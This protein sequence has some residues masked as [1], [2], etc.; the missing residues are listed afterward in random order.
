MKQIYI[1]V[2]LFAFSTTFGQVVKGAPWDMG[3]VQRR[4][5][6]PTLEE[7]AKHAEDYFK[8][9]DRN[10]KGSGFK[11]F[12]RWEYH[13][14]NYLKPDGTIAPVQD[15]WSAWEQK[16]ALGQ[17]S[18]S[19]RMDNSDWKPLGPYTNSNT[20]SANNLKQ[21]GQG[22]VNAIA[23]DPNN[24]NTY[25]IGAPAGGIWKS[26]D[27]GL[28]WTP[29]TDHLP[30][31][32]VSGIAINP[33]N[34]N[35]IYI[36]TGD[37]DANDSPTVGVW[38]TTDGG[39]TWNNTG[40]IPGSP[41]SMN[42]I[43]FDPNNTNTLLVATSTGVQKTTNGG[44]SWTT[45]LAGNIIDIK[46]K[47]GDA[48]IWY[49]VSRD[50]FYKSTDG[51]ESFNEVALPGLGTSG[52]LTMDVTIADPDYVYVVSA[53]GN[54]AFNGI[55][56]STNSGTSFTKTAETDD[57]F[58]STQAWFDLALTVSDKNADIIYVGVLDIWKSING[59]DSFTKINQ[60]FNPNT[61]TYTHADIHFLRFIDGKFFAGTDGGIFVSTDEARSFTD[62]TKNLAISQFYRISVSQQKP[63]I[64]AGGLQ[65]NGGFGYD[66]KDWRN[67]HGGDGMEGQV[68]PN[69]FK[70]FYGFTQFGG[71]L[72][73]SSNSGQSTSLR[74]G[75]PAEETDSENNDSGG[76]WITPMT[77]NKEGELYAGYSQIYRLNGNAWT[78]ISNHNFGGDD[79][80]VLA[81]DP[82]NSDIMYVGQGIR[83][84][85]SIDRGQTFSDITFNQGQ[86]RSIVPH[87]TEDGAIWVVTPGAVTK[88]SNLSAFFP[89]SETI[90][91]NTP[92]EGL[93]TLKSHQRSGKNTL[94]LGTNLGVYFIND[95]L[96]E[97]QTFDN[98]L[99]NVQ[100][101]D[102]DINEEDSKLY[103]A[104]Y[105]RGIFSTDIPRQLPPSDVRLISIND[106]VE[107]TIL[108]GNDLAPEI[109]IRNQGAQPLT[110]VT[111]NYNIDGGANQVYN[112]NGNIA[113]ETEASITLPVISSSKGEHILNIESTTASDEYSSNNK[114]SINFAINESSTSP[115]TENTFENDSDQLL[116]ITTNSPMWTIISSAKTELNIPSGSRAYSTTAGE[117]PTNTTGYLYTNCYN[118][119]EI[120][121]PTLRF[122]MGFDIELNWDYMVVEYSTNQ[123]TNWE[124]L[125]SATD[126]NWYN[127]DA[128]TDA[129]NR[130]TLPGKQW[131]GA[132]DANG[133]DGQPNATIKEYSHDL[134]AL[135]NET[136]VIFRFRFLSDANTVGE[137]AVID[138][139]VIS[140]VLSTNDET[141]LKG[142]AIYPNPSESIFNINRN[143]SDQ[144]TVK[145]FDLAGKQIYFDKNI[146]DTNYTIDLSAYAKGIYVLNMVSDGKT[147]TRKLI[148]K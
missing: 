23:V 106:I 31:I 102:L 92:T 59:G 138:N 134:A 126:P 121:N 132:G 76:E 30:Q 28:N 85:R 113:S 1:I 36:A 27:A 4:G 60:W 18:A 82:N 8:T 46:M 112:W 93:T 47:P 72:T 105:G 63:N 94:Y 20:Y 24:S 137:G 144:L 115:T 10:K 45:K 2:L 114:G 65:D 52:R 118:L 116:T 21:T 81:I 127:S 142:I 19:Q 25:Y 34:S 131:T 80:D 71:S 42:E 11:P 74:V 38:K 48:N 133:P 139:L 64:I 9:I 14:S 87:P 50:T 56:K 68:D 3:D 119:S 35:E 12:K 44:T 146:T 79:I 54:F 16:K 103:V 83:L 109:T 39:T 6:K 111:I 107:G 104:T 15:L 129:T 128:T 143:T 145:V 91:T 110:S 7:M 96:T 100:V 49:A 40:N 108:C 26:T 29:L 66:G 55:Y 140:G 62:L 101:R 130:S 86:I 43:Y 97:W 51:G 41:T 125:G 69:N 73:R 58:N 84:F 78:K 57:I 98:N 61:P 53:A 77:I 117:Y 89:T 75:A 17:R 90:G 33:D 148:L 135:A 22:R 70:V 141:F 37:D 120:I 136:S 95:E 122:N 147:A 123:G 13:W 5:T 99:P 67:Y 124:I 88:L 32:G